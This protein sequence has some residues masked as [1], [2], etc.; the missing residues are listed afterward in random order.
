MTKE[1]EIRFLNEEIT[2]KNLMIENL[3]LE[4]AELRHDFQELMCFSLHI[5]EELDKSLLKNA[6]LSLCLEAL[7]R[8]NK[9]THELRKD[10]EDLLKLKGLYEDLSFQYESLVNEKMQLEIE[11]KQ[12]KSQNQELFNEIERLQNCQ[13]F[14]KTKKKRSPIRTSQLAMKVKLLF[15]DFNHFP[16]ISFI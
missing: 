12:L 14:E 3:R 5:K 8:E 6:D 11:R 1:E 4:L 13:I 15:Q 2:G 9:K 16:T 7:R 10:S